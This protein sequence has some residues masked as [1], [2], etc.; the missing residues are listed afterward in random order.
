MDQ[1]L[2][3]QCALVTGGAR[4]VGAVIVRRLHAAGAN[5][6]VHCHRS[7][8]AA[9]V[10]AAELN[11]LRPASAAVACADL[12]DTAA[13]PGLAAQALSAFGR[14]DLLVNNAS[15]FYPTPIDAIDEAQWLDLI[16]TNLKAPLFLARAAAP[17]LRER[18]GAIVNIIDIH[19]E[20]PMRDHLIYNA[21]K[22]GLAALTRALALDL[23]PQ[24][25]VNGVSPGAIVWP[26]AGAWEDPAEREAIVRRTIL[27]RTGAPEDIAGAVLY[28]AG[29]PY[30]TGQILAVDGGRS[31][32]L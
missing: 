7:R 22:G 26:E 12:L 9:G 8:D 28:L 16:G 25:R 14:L 11:A 24:V 6:V 29:A 31:I 19:A 32:V 23:G 10:L 5:V 4:R 3:H 18:G 17:A 2:Q 20:R 30:V 13:L 15:S 27:G 21:A 1:L